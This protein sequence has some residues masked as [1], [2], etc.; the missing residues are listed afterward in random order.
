MSQLVQFSQ[1]YKQSQQ[2]IPRLFENLSVDA[3]CCHLVES[4]ISQH[5]SARLFMSELQAVILVE[6]YFLL[7]DHFI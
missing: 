5:I 2:K 4:R 7:A 1:K 3:R 6:E